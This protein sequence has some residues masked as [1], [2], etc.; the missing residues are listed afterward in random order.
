MTMSIDR[1]FVNAMCISRQKSLLG[2]EK[3]AR[4]L[5]AASFDEAY[6]MLGEM[7]FGDVDSVSA[8]E[9]EQVLLAE[10]MKLYDFVRAYAPTDAIRAYCLA[11]R[12]AYN[13]EYL[14]R[15]AYV[16]LPEARLV[17]GEVPMERLRKGIDG[18][19]QVLPAWL[20]TPIRES[21]AM[22]ERGDATG[23]AVSTVFLR[24]LYDYLLA[25]CR[26]GQMRRFVQWQIDTKNISV[27][28]RA[29]KL[30]EL[31]AMWIEGGQISLASLVLLLKRDGTAVSR[32]FMQT[33]YSAVIRAAMD[34]KEQNKPLVA[35]ENA[36]DSEFLRS[37]LPQKYSCEGVE[38]FLLYFGYRANDIAN[39]R[40]VL[41]AKLAGADKDSIKARLRVS[42]GE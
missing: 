22:F 3:I 12:D 4:L 36:V 10:Q 28:L 37:L 35:Y 8:A 13:A 21:Q 2:K 32:R 41:A 11:P 5:D 16:T 17:P 34:A 38:P 19:Y 26:F 23:V 39:V 9:Y 30:S 29:G 18:S 6:R 15:Q 33:D 42:Y 27:A 24:A 31:E 7:G 40:V 1:T 25:V 14:V 20:V